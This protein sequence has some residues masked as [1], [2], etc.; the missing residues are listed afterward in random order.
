MNDLPDIIAENELIV[1]FADDSSL[2]VWTKTQPEL[3]N[4]A[5]TLLDE[6]QNWFRRNGL[7]LN[8]EKTNT[9]LFQTN[10]T[11]IHKPTSINVCNKKYKLSEN[12]KFLGV[13]VDDRLKWD[14]HIEELK[15]SLDSVCYSMRVIAKYVTKNTLKIVYHANLEARIRYGIV[16][17]GA[18]NIQPIFKSQKRALRIL[19]KMKYRQSCRGEFKKEKILTTYAI[20]IQECLIFLFKNT[21]LFG[22]YEKE[23]NYTTINMDYLYPIHRLANTEKNCFYSCIKFYNK[24]PSYVKIENQ[25]KRYILIETDSVDEYMSANLS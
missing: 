6:S 5:E 20:F 12:T 8:E 3:I 19:R 9:I 1:N 13:Y 11:N 14:K 24:S 7:I 16:F 18:K 23:G 2:L 21:H 15:Q 22:K 10:Y 25:L 17:Y 4:S